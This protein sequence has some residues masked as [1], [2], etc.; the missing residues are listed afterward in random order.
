MPAAQI[1]TGTPFRCVPAH[2]HPCMSVTAA[3]TASTLSTNMSTLLR[4]LLSFNAELNKY[5]I[6]FQWF[7]FSK[8]GPGYLHTLRICLLTTWI[9]FADHEDADAA[10]RGMSHTD[11]RTARFRH[12]ID[13][14]RELLPSLIGD[15]KI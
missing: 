9:L 7:H 15:T 14:M 11:T 13:L 3:G 1:P 4:L 10:R 12:N 6:S 2:L 5:F 8:N